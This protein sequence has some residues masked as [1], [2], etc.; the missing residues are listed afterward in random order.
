MGTVVNEKPAEDVD[1]AESEST[2]EDNQEP[3][4]EQ[5]EDDFMQALEDSN[6]TSDEDQ[7]DEDGEKAQSQE[8]EDNTDKEKLEDEG[9]QN[10]NEG[11]TAKGAEQRKEQLN[12]EIRELVAQRNALR[13]DIS[14]RIK[15]RY[16][17]QNGQAQS[18]DELVN[19]INPETGDYYTRAEAQAV[20]Q[21]NRLDQIEQERKYEAYAAQVADSQF[22]MDQESMQVVKDFPMFDSESDQ[23]DKELATGA[24]EIIKGAVETDSQ[25]GM[26][27]G[28]RVPI[29]QF[30]ALL[31]KSAESA[32]KQGEIAGREAAQKMM[33]TVDAIGSDRNQ[34]GS[35]TE[36]DDFEKELLED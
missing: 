18:V 21:N 19:T 33:G 34:K 8:S 30:Y 1:A 16:G 3:Q 26:I 20:I 17:A 4:A 14:R 6:S 2:T 23:Y 27:I 11:Q 36:L 15:E 13:E 35:D 31:A 24:A 9:E 10:P 5:P 32:K 28:C 12:S 7:S 29:Y 25:T 22:M